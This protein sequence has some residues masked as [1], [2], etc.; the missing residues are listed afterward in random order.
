MPR[1]QAFPRNRRSGKHA[2]AVFSAIVFVLA[3]VA[4]LPQPH[5]IAMRSGAS[6]L[7]AQFYGLARLG[8]VEESSTLYPLPAS[9]SAFALFNVASSSAQVRLFYAGNCSTRLVYNGRLPQA[10]SVSNLAVSY[11]SGRL[12][13]VSFKYGRLSIGYF[14]MASNNVSIVSSSL[15]IGYSPKILSSLAVNDSYLA[16]YA[17]KKRDTVRIMYSLTVFGGYNYNPVTTYY[18]IA[19]I[20]ASGESAY[21]PLRA[22]VAYSRSNNWF[23]IAVSFSSQSNTSVTEFLIVNPTT[24]KTLY[25][26]VFNR[27]FIL[28]IPGDGIIYMLESATLRVE[29]S[30]PEVLLTLLEARIV[31]EKGPV[32][33]LYLEEFNVTYPLPQP[34]PGVARA[35]I[36]NLGSLLHPSSMNQW[37]LDWMLPN[38]RIWVGP[39]EAHILSLPVPQLSSNGL[40]LVNL[41]S[42]ETRLLYT[43]FYPKNI[44]SPS[45]PKPYEVSLAAAP[46][47]EKLYA[48]A[49]GLTLAPEGRPSNV[50]LIALIEWT[51]PLEGL[52]ASIFEA[53]PANASY[54]TIIENDYDSITVEAA[55]LNDTLFLVL[56][57]QSRRNIY[58]SPLLEFHVYAIQLGPPNLTALAYSLNNATYLSITS[59]NDRILLGATR[60]SGITAYALLEESSTPWSKPIFKQLGTAPLG[61]IAWLVTSASWTGPPGNKSLVLTLYDALD[62]SCRIVNVYPRAGGGIASRTLASSNC[63]E[64]TYP[65][66]THVSQDS[67]G[68]VSE[69]LALERGDS[70]NNT[71]VLLLSGNSSR[72]ISIG[73]TLLPYVTGYYGSSSGP[74]IGSLLSAPLVKG[75]FAPTPDRM[76][77]VA[78]RPFNPLW[79]SAGRPRAYAPFYS[80]RVKIISWNP[81]RVLATIDLAGIPFRIAGFSNNTLYLLA[82]NP[83]QPHKPLLLA[84]DSTTGR[85]EEAIPLS[86]SVHDLASFGVVETSRGLVIYYG[87]LIIRLENV[88]IIELIPWSIVREYAITQHANNATSTPATPNNATST[89]TRTPSPEPANT[90]KTLLSTSQTLET[91]NT[92]ERTWKH[93]TTALLSTAAIAAALLAAGAS[94]RRRSRRRSPNANSSGGIEVEVYL[95]SRRQLGGG[96]DERESGNRRGGGER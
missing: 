86:I 82:M 23:E 69:V 68:V 27:T 57:K 74:G 58:Y 5:A 10:I 33:S 54:M 53:P 56:A 18:H 76:A 88:K 6:G 13:F 51:A 87:K 8:I 45:P 81:L 24:G 90:S 77:V 52:P 93:A 50:G 30:V 83:F 91:R 43:P 79:V 37:V 9:S 3:V 63:G 28:G 65:L 89:R 41:T 36:Y 16:V 15:M 96:G 4:L 92:R 67:R 85:L 7:D 84:Y 26:T 1:T 25:Y 95:L 49:R 21:P 64:S 2:T 75:A 11:S 70:S 78:V 14:S 48:A 80:G 35:I 61:G 17:L 20:P 47:G 55:A 94:L 40:L 22:V 38:T 59:D 42:L 39:R 66:W 71:V 34:T 44:S 73:D 46:G 60:V 62:H 31:A 32:S 12:Y 29:D 19:T 72:R